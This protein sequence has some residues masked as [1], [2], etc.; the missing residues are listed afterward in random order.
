MGIGSLVGDECL[1]DRVN[2][3]SNEWQCNICTLIN[4]QSATK[5]DA[6]SALKP[7]QK[8]DDEKNEKEDDKQYKISKQLALFLLTQILSIFSND[9]LRNVIITI[10]MTQ[11]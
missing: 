9:K 7:Q 1:D 10:L 8:N 2:I 5:C 4:N 3:K 11:N 6:C